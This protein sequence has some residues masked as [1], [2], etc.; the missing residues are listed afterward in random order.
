MSQDCPHH[1]VH[2]RCGAGRPRSICDTF[3]VGIVF[4]TLVRTTEASA[5]EQP[6]FPG[7]ALRPDLSIPRERMPLSTAMMPIPANYQAIDLP[8]SKSSSSEEFRPRGRSIMEIPPHFTVSDEAPM[9]RGTTVWQRLSDYRSRGRVRILT[10]WETGGGSISLQ[11]GKRGDPSLQWTSRLMNRG[12]AT[13]GVFDQ[14]FATSFAGAR[15]MHFPGHSISSESNAKP[16][17]LLDVG[18]PGAQ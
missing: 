6:D 15:G 4:L 3:L 17:K 10:L 14:L 2:A 5:G 11:A 8:E 9:L 18:A 7:S 13:R 1:V 16:T 12:G